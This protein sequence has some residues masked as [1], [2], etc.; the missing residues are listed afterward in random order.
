MIEGKKEVDEEQ[1]ERLHT[2]LRPFLLRRLKKDVEKQLPQK[3]EHI[4][5]CKLSKRQR[6]LYEDFMS[7][8]ETKSDLESGSLFKVLG[9][10]MQ[11]RK[12]CNHP[13]LFDSRP[14][15]SPFL[16]KPLT[17]QPPKEIIRI[18]EQKPFD[19]VNLDLLGLNFIKHETQS[20]YEVELIRDL[21]QEDDIEKLKEK[22]S[23]I[24]LPRIKYPNM[25]SYLSTLSTF[26]ENEKLERLK[27]MSN[28][29]KIKCRNT[30]LLFGRDLVSSLTIEMKQN[31]LIKP[32][33]RIWDLPRKGSE[34]IL[35]PENRFDQMKEIIETFT[36]YIPKVQSIQPLTKCIASP[37]ESIKF[38]QEERMKEIAFSPLTDIY[39]PGHIRTKMYFPDKRLIQVD[40]GKFYVLSNLLRKLKTEGHRVLIFTQMSKMLDILE[41]FLCM[42]GVS[43]VRLD[44]STK[45]EMRQYLMDKFNNDPKIFVFILSTRSGGVGVNLTGADTVIFYDSDWNPAMDLQ[46]QDRCHRIGQ[47]KDVHIYRLI[48]ESTI[49]ERILLK[50]HQKKTMNEVII[51]S[52]GFTTEMFKKVDMREIFNESLKFEKAIF[53]SASEREIQNALTKVEDSADVAALKLAEKEIND[54]EK[55][56]DDIEN[57][58]DDYSKL[59]SPIEQYFFFSIK[60]RFALKY[61]EFQKKEDSL[62]ELKKIEIE[63]KRDEE[64]FISSLDSKN[65][66]L[67]NQTSENVDEQEEEDEFYYE[68]SKLKC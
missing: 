4:V 32:N 58:E 60:S 6:L 66:L 13:D 37:D 47:T 46:A 26:E 30:H 61:L 1:I 52:G 43:F 34:L 20:A 21:Y 42:L 49:E 53:S 29:N 63:K 67:G 62:E 8:A 54:F 19:S 55:E 50:A 24:K 40:C 65:P 18:L 25:N 59:L 44:G 45:I 2:I 31:S 3:Y 35:T 22:S 5:K 14:I 33:L 9:I 7:R 51:Q 16:T 17:I 10:I 28:L 48:S 41:E 64:N 68:V 11:L 36:I 15:V 12:V 38:E 27:R 23:S 57:E 56:I 39:R